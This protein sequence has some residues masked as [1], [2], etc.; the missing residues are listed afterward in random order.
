[1]TTSY[2]VQFFKKLVDDFST[3]EEL[4]KGSSYFEQRLL[5]IHKNIGKHKNPSI[6]SSLNLPLGQEIYLVWGEYSEVTSTG[7][8]VNSGV[9]PLAIFKDLDSAQTFAQTVGQINDKFQK[10]SDFY[11]QPVKVTCLDQQIITI[12]NPPWNS[13]TC[14]LE[15]VKFDKVILRG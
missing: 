4:S 2:R 8:L 15:S 12:N 3:N 5:S 14:K 9:T 11:W 6:T 7:L 1:M 10:E 13:D